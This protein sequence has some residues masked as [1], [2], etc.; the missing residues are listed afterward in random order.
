VARGVLRKH[1]ARQQRENQ[2][3]DVRLQD[4]FIKEHG[5]ESYD[6][7]SAFRSQTDV[8]SIRNEL[9]KAF[10]KDIAVERAKLF[11]LPSC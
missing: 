8:L 1:D 10:E 3:Q 2:I 9:L 5:E 7:K 6:Y 4:Y 11:T